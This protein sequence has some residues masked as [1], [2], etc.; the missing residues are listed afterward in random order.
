MHDACELL[1]RMDSGFHRRLQKGVFKSHGDKVVFGLAAF[2]AFLPDDEDDFQFLSSVEFLRQSL[3]HDE[4]DILHE[5]IFARETEM[6]NRLVGPR[7]RCDLLVNTH[8]SDESDDASFSY[9]DVAWSDHLKEDTP[10]LVQCVDSGNSFSAMLHRYSG[11]QET[12]VGVQGQC[13]ISGCT[14]GFPEGRPNG[15]NCS[16]LKQHP[17][18]KHDKE[19]VGPLCMMHYNQIYATNTRNRLLSKKKS[20]MRSE[21]SWQDPVAACSHDNAAP[22]TEMDVHQQDQITIRFHDPRI[23]TQ[24]DVVYL[25]ALTGSRW[26]FDKSLQ[27]HVLVPRCVHIIPEDHVPLRHAKTGTRFRQHLLQC[28]HNC[29]KVL[30]NL[31]LFKCVVCKNRLVT[32]HPDHQPPEQLTVTKTYVNAVS[33]WDTSPTEERTKNASFH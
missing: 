18:S 23:E 19:T 30:G 7:F 2:Q 26:T 5:D 8:C 27:E 32:F 16:F 25:R 28:V 15:F 13:C 24:K 6:W 21:E 12:F 33:E 3:T 14:H 11:V 20:S 22:T 29:H 10:L 1:E 9:R 17:K 4:Q 31:V